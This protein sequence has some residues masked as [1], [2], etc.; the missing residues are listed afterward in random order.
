MSIMKATGGKF[1]GMKKD[2]AMLWKPTSRIYTKNFIKR[3][4]KLAV[5]EK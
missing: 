5:V 1:R 2:N 4:P 3:F